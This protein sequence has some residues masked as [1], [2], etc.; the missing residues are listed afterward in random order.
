MKISEDW[1]WLV[2]LAVVCFAVFA[3]SLSGEF[4][5]DD[6]RQLVRNPLIQQ[7][8]LIGKALTS[9][10]WA[11]K[12]D[13]TQTASNYWRPTFTAWNIISY[14]LFGATPF[15][16]HLTSLLLHIGVTLLAFALLRR[17]QFSATAAFVISLIFAVHPTKVESVAWIAG[18]PDLLFSLFFLASLWFMTSYRE[19]KS[20]THLALVILFYALSLG[21]KEI[22]ILLLPIYYLVLRDTGETK[23][24]KG[25]MNMPLIAL[26]ITAAI[27]FVARLGVIG[28][29]SHPTEGSVDLMTGLLTAPKMFAFYVK[30][31]FFPLT[32][33]A[34]YPLEPVTQIDA[35][36]FLLPLLLAVGSVAF[37]IYLAGKTKFGY[38]GIALLLLPLI[39]AMNA[40][41][42]NPD[43][44]VHD[45]YLYLPILGL[46]I[47]LV[48]LIEQYID[49]QK[50]VA[51]GAIISVGLAVLTFSYNRA[52]ANEL[53][54][55][56]WTSKMDN[57]AFT[58]SQYGSALTESGRND[59][60]I[61]AYTASLDKRVSA[62]GYLGRARSNIALQRFAEAENDLAK[63][64]E[65]RDEDID[66][67]TLY[68]A[69]EAL[70][71]AYLGKNDFV[72]A[73]K[74]F[75]TARARL[76]LYAAA[77]TEKLAIV[78]YQK[79]DKAMALSELESVREKAKSEMLPES[80]SVFLRLG[81]LY[82]EQNR[83]D[84]A[85]SMLQNYLT[86]TSA[87]KSP[88]VLRD[89]EQATSLLQKLR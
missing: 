46:L 63:M 25:W 14:R 8:A 71:I 66:V 69:F 18:S 48:P 9:D 77:L 68:Q 83:L 76:P 19:S 6:T 32:L 17:W 79:G 35:V 86:M 16:W 44:L 52:W 89:R 4:V 33:G 12:G 40:T 70:G 75:R 10:V 56:K 42:F 36:G 62:R 49:R 29:L 7:N 82:A 84:E 78:L 80:K 26:G 58:W 45:R 31:M 85:R 41:A 47:I 20:S 53:A 43:Q 21:A 28:R 30:Q 67:Y 61:K 73:E 55:W 24:K 34:N 2:V 50:L 11:F 27:Y 13:G 72:A 37:L 5:Y 3:N 88:A 87:M 22:G 15:G 81:M 57:S 39:P 60:A 59:E 74:N 65:L 51:A 54:L 23:Q 38:L 64:I 1:K